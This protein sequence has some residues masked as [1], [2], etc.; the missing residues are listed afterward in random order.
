MP[1]YPPQYMPQQQP[2]T[3]PKQFYEQQQQQQQ[4]QLYHHPSYIR[5]TRP[6]PPPPPSHTTSM[7]PPQSATIANPL[8]IL[9]TELLEDFSPHDIMSLPPE[10]VS[11]WTDPAPPPP[12]PQYFPPQTIPS[13]ESVASVF[14]NYRTNVG[15]SPADLEIIR[16]TKRLKSL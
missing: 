15:H 9:E 7:S 13:S 14:Y 4:Q 2:Q 10:L 3:Y 5:S 16:E 12:P 6:S 1:R 11:R 8:D